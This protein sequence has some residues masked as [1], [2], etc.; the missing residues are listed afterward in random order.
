METK[1]NLFGHTCRMGDQRLVK[2]VM[3]GM[4]DG[5]SLRERPSREW[6]V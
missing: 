5:M 2:N 3:F 4:V 6:L 1:L